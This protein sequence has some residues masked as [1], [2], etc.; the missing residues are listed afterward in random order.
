MTY[1]DLT[2]LECNV[3]IHD[4]KNPSMIISICL[5]VL[6]IIEVGFRSVLTSRRP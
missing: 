1:N 6:L 4:K 2:K 5:F 3:E